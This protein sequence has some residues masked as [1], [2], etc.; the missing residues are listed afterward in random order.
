MAFQIFHGVLFFPLVL[1]A[2]I[3]DIREFF[4]YFSIL[5]LIP[6]QFIIHT[7]GVLFCPFP[8]D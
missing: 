7:Q 3:Q 8:Y 1:L 6:G 2:E 4:I 5:L